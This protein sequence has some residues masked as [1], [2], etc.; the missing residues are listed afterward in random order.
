M[1]VARRP[2]CAARRVWSAG[3]RSEDRQELDGDPNKN[4]GGHYE[5]KFALTLNFRKCVP[6]PGYKGMERPLHSLVI[7]GNRY[8][9]PRVRFALALRVPVRAL[10][11]TTPQQ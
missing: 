8:R 2:L 11:G 4:K 7:T 1:L 10:C 3:R 5:D 6:A 9:L